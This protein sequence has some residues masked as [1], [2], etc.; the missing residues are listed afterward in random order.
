MRVSRPTEA[1][2]PNLPETEPAAPAAASAPEAHQGPSPFGKLL[3]GLGRELDRG[4]ALTEKA[5]ELVL[6]TA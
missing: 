1:M 3:R 2:L 4:E 6:A 5:I